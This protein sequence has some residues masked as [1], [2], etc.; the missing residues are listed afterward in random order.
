MAI[1]P[2][3]ANDSQCYIPVQT[4]HLNSILSYS[5]VY[6]TS[7]LGHVPGI[8]N[9][10]NSWSL[11]FPSE[12][13]M[14]SSSFFSISMNV[15]ATWS[16]SSQNFQINLDTFLSSSILKSNTSSILV[17]FTLE[18][19]SESDH[20]S[21]PQLTTLILPVSWTIKNCLLTISL[22][23]LLFPQSLPHAAARDSFRY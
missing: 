3:H 17:G 16:F 23:P 21:C 14:R 18:I 22:L 9:I 8:L 5:A 19:C 15:S 7:S 4:T 12:I 20:S 13:Q 11:I 1:K 10:T 2:L 6:L